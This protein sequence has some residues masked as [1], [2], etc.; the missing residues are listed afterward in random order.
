VLT[1]GSADITRG[2]PLRGCL[3]LLHGQSVRAGCL[4]KL[5][6]GTIGEALR[7]GTD[8]RHN[9]IEHLI[10]LGTQ[11]GA[12]NLNFN[13]VVLD[14]PFL[15]IP[16]QDILTFQAHPAPWN[17]VAKISAEWNTP[18]P[19]NGFDNVSFL[20]AWENPR[21][22]ATVVNVES[23]LMLNGF[24]DALAESGLNPDTWGHH[25][26][27]VGLT[28]ELGIFEWWNNPPTS[29]SGQVGQFA[30]AIGLFADGGGAFGVGEY[31]WSGAS[32][33]Y[34]V[35]YRSFLIPPR[36][37]ALFEV[38]LLIGHWT[39]GGFIDVDFTS[40]DFEIMCPAVV[41]AILT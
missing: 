33:T 21:D 39:D 1:A 23:Y 2:K 19:D 3:Q 30:S 34:D 32:G 12:A 15:I 5:P 26:T 24:C 37:V 35:N 11:A 20:F 13:F 29:P 28:I 14:T 40:G 10:S 38:T 22:T 16:S 25:T 27:T 6:A 36:G 4:C 18:Y 31:V 17:N 8:S 7:Y 9:A 41:M